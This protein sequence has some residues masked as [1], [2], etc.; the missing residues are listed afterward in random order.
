MVLSKSTDLQLNNI[1][2]SY[3]IKCIDELDL[4]HELKDKLN[5]N[6]YDRI[7]ELA[8]K[9]QYLYMYSVCKKCNRISNKIRC[10]GEIGSRIINKSYVPYVISDKHKILLKDSIKN[11]NNIKTIPNIKIVNKLSLEIIDELLKR[12]I[13]YDISNYDKLK[14]VLF[15]TSKMYGNTIYY[16]ENDYPNE[17]EVINDIAKNSNH[18]LKLSFED[19][20]RLYEYWSKIFT[21]DKKLYD[22][23]DIE[24]Y[25]LFI[26]KDDEYPHLN[27]IL[28]KLWIELNS[29]NA[30]IPNELLECSTFTIRKCEGDITKQRLLGKYPTITNLLIRQHLT[31]PKYKEVPNL[32][33]CDASNKYWT[34][35]GKDSYYTINHNI[36]KKI[37]ANYPF[38][39]RLIEAPYKNFCGSGKTIYPTR[40]LMPGSALSI[41]LYQYIHTLVQRD[42]PM[43]ITYVDDSRIFAN[44][45]DSIDIIE[46]AFN[47]YNLELNLKKTGLHEVNTYK[48]D[49]FCKKPIVV[50]ANNYDLTD[51]DKV[52]LNRLYNAKLQ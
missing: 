28:T 27:F 44:V 31:S 21:S 29:P 4:I 2:E 26:K 9:L 3:R 30:E 12:I 41:H 45:P 35:D 18:K 24:S 33:R 6:N 43:C 39:I 23:I 34:I 36:A 22:N 7:V 42:C 13:E 52:E 25:D 40:G 8:V 48:V 20:N 16:S 38:L 47:K 50:L 17:I 37:V 51:E 5:H 49:L 32:V 11:L 1:S 10:C 19:K 46:Q 15:T 14:I